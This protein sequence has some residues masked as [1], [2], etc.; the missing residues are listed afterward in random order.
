LAPAELLCRGLKGAGLNPGAEAQ[1]PGPR[2][3]RVEARGQGI[4]GPH[5]S[6]MLARCKNHASMMQRPLYFSWPGQ[7]QPRDQGRTSWQPGQQAD[8]RQTAGQRC[9]QNRTSKAGAGVVVMNNKQQEQD[10]QAVG[11]QTR[12]GGGIAPSR[13]GAAHTETIGARPLE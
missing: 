11:R 12:P 2:G 1:A 10:K 9:R 7:Q 8:N 5:Y 4:G 13:P 3:Q 6:M